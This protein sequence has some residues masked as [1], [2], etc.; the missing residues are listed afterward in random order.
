MTWR[1]RG[2][3]FCHGFLG[4]PGREWDPHQSVAAIAVVAGFKFPFR[5]NRI[6]EGAGA[7]GKAQDFYSTYLGGRLHDISELPE[8]TWVRLL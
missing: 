6:G 5:F 2:E 3:R 4:T 8:E 1:C 7:G